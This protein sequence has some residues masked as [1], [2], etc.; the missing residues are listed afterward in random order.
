MKRIAF[1]LLGLPLLAQKPTVNVEP[2]DFSTVMTTVQAVFGTQMELG[3]GIQ[4]V[5]VDRITKGGKFTV[6]ERA[7]VNTIIAE[8]DFGA[9]GRVKRGTQAKI[10]EIKGSQFTIFGDIVTFGRDDG[11]KAAGAVVVAGGV[12]AG[13]VGSKSTNRAVVTIAFRMVNTET[14]EVVMTGE[15]RGESKR[16]SKNGLAGFISGAVGIGAGYSMNS[17]NFAETIIGEAVIDACDKLARQVESQAGA[18]KSTIN[19]QIEGMVASVDGSTLYVNVGSAAGVQV[20]DTFQ[21]SH[22]V[23]EVRDPVTKELLDLQTTPAGTL[24]VTTVREKIS[25][26]TISGGTAQIGDR[27]EKK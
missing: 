15:A 9:S 2:F 1:F 16:E 12:G 23:K 8:Q 11:R 20:G 18:V 3:K 25:I 21:V 7:R 17:S 5:M 26:G 24:R 13:A 22:V 10:G 19:A 4:A 27:V 14:S 6:V